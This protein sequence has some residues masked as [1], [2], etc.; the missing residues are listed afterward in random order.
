MTL[1]NYLP[2]TLIVC[3]AFIASCSDDEPTVNGGNEDTPQSL[4]VNPPALGEDVLFSCDFQATTDADKFVMWDVDGLSPSYAMQTLGFATGTPWIFTFRDSYT[5]TNYYAGSTSSY[6]PAGQANDWL[7]TKDA[8]MIPDSG[9]VLTWN[10]QALDM[11]LRDG[12]SV[13][14]STTGN[15]PDDF[16]Q[17]AVFHVDEEECGASENADGEWTTHNVALDDYAGQNIWVAFVNDSYDKGVL[18][19]DDIE[20]ARHQ[21]LTLESLVPAFTT[22]G[23][24]TV[25][26]RVTAIDE[27]VDSFNAY[28]MVDSLNQFGETFSDLALSPGESYEFSITQPMTLSEA[29]GFT[30]FQMWVEYGGVSEMLVDSVARTAFEPMHKVVIEEGTGQW[31]GW[32][33][34]G[35]IAMEYLKEQYPDQFIGIAVHNGDVMTVTEY[36]RGLGFSAFPAGIA[37]RSVSCQPMTATYELTGAGTFHDTFLAELD[38]LP[39]AEVR[40]TAVSMDSDSIVSFTSQTRFALNPASSDYR[41]AY[42]IMSNNYVAPGGQSNYLYNGNGYP[43]FGEFGPGGQYGTQVIARYPYDDVACCIEPEFG[44]AAGIIPSSVSLG[45]TYA[46]DFSIDL[47][48]CQNIAEGV[49]LELVAMLI[50]GSDGSIVN[51]DKYVIAE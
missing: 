37:N 45:E 31:C 11:V 20:I 26:G 51:A 14:V 38:K 48:E 13:Y 4:P 35:I 1:K 27:E 17:P 5:S 18:L 36:D 7:V 24:V 3:S 39:E 34:T 8:V 43:I 12:L 2:L 10:S 33:P 42:V 15:T 49:G 29:G 6:T 16:T 46:H 44:G 21:Y 9:Y 41:L 25:T 32:C 22:E 28:F 50:D 47:K 40:L 30:R 23:Q 19:L